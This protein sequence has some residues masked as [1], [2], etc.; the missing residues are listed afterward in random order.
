MARF[1]GEATPRQLEVIGF[2]PLGA[3]LWT[4]EFLKGMSE[5]YPGFCP[6]RYF[7]A[8]EAGELSNQ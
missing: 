2:P 4:D 6:E 5:R 1:I 7:L 8:A 3:P